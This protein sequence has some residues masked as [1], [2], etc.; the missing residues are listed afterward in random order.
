MSETGFCFRFRSILFDCFVV[1]LAY[2]FCSLKRRKTHL[3]RPIIMAM[4]AN[5]GK[6]DKNEQKKE[7]NER[8]RMQ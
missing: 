1:W 8:K 7:L 3:K 2:P 6:S 4:T 5:T